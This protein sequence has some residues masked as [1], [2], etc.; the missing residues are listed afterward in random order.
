MGL[1]SLVQFY[2]ELA[3]VSGVRLYSVQVKYRI[4]QTPRP[5]A[6]HFALTILVDST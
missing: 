6:V 2:M 3:P 5:S 4:L 1:P